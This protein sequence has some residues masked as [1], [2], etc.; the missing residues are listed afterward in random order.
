MLAKAPT[1][2]EGDTK[3]KFEEGDSLAAGLFLYSFSCPEMSGAYNMKSVDFIV[4]AGKPEA[5]RAVSFRR[6]P[7]KVGDIV[8]DGDAV[9]ATNSSFD[10]NSMTLNTFSKGRGIGDCGTEEAWV[11]D[12]KAF[13]LA[14]LKLMRMQGSAAG[15]LAG[16]V[17]RTSEAIASGN[18]FTSAH[19]R[20]TPSPAVSDRQRL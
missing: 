10:P 7:V 14:E 15:G 16:G 4:P 1:A 9:T 8:H 12:G 19:R 18:N 6:W 20:S 11:F 3:A 2:C 5:A 13:Q 17:S